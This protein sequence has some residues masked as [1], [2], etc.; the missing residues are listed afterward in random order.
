[1]PLLGVMEAPQLSQTYMEE[2]AALHESMHNDPAQSPAAK[3]GQEP[4]GKGENDAQTMSTGR[5]VR[6]LPMSVGVSPLVRY[7]HYLPSPCALE[8]Y[9]GT[10]I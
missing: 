8:V 3:I 1:M 7:T 6:G 5:Q 9:P 2:L 4:G 10:Y